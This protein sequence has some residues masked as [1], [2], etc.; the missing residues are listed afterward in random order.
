M[1]VFFG[2]TLVALGFCVVLFSVCFQ[3]AEAGCSL[4]GGD[5]SKRDWIFTKCGNS[6][7]GCS[8]DYCLSSCE[9]YAVFATCGCNQ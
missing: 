6:L 2:K 1:C 5:C 9:C 8:G 3:R 4:C 7:T